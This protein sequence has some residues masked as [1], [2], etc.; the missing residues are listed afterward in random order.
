MR[1]FLVAFAPR[2]ASTSCS[3]S[4]FRIRL[5]ASPLPSDHKCIEIVRAETE[6]PRPSTGWCFQRATQRPRRTPD[7]SGSKS[8]P[9]VNNLGLAIFLEADAQWDEG[10]ACSR[11]PRRRFDGSTEIGAQLTANFNVLPPPVACKHRN[12]GAWDP[13]ISMPSTAATNRPRDQSERS[14]PLRFRRRAIS[15]P[16]AQTEPR[17]LPVAAHSRWCRR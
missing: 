17:A 11:S 8:G 7:Q 6:V 13:Q 4:S 5:S 9:A 1:L 15:Q 16:R 14:T 12:S 3:Y 10:K 2:R